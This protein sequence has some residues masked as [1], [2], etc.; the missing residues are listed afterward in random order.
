MRQGPTR[1][2]IPEL[3][4]ARL[5]SPTI[6]PRVVWILAVSVLAAMLAPSRVLADA[7]PASDVLLLQNVFYPYNPSVSTS[8]QNVL[9]AETAAANHT[10]FPI[11]VA[12]I[13]QPEDLGAIP[14]LFDK[15]QPYAQF[16]DQEISDVG[17]H[18]PVL[19][20]MPDGYGIKGLP[21]TAIAAAASLAKPAGRD[22][23]DL[24]RAA[25][26]AVKSIS[27]AAGHPL[28]NIHDQSNTGNGNGSTPLTVAILAVAAA[29]AAGSILGARRWR[30]QR[31]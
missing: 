2:K 4:A 20:V 27:A 17:A 30:H 23:N 10:G 29:V 19:V 15:P 13:D 9:N 14:S 8:L 12:L 21:P 25:I 18:A 22:S 26:I 11:K 5:R 1:R 7:D 24:A 28:D 31:G 3:A 6:V 16:L